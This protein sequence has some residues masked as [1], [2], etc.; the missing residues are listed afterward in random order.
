VSEH[1]T[2]TIVADFE[3]EIEDG[4]LP[5]P[6]CMVA[7]VL[8][9]HLRHVRTIRLWRE[10]LL[11]SKHPP[12][13]IGPD[14]LFVAY[15]AWADMTCFKVLGWQFPVH[16][17]DPHTAYLAASNVLLPYDPDEVRK[18][19]RK[20]LPDACR[21]YSIEGWGRIDKEQ[22]SED[23]GTGSWRK[24]GKEAVL[25]YCEEDVKKSAELLRAQLRGL[26]GLPP[27]DVPRTLFWSNYSASDGVGE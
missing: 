15:S 7:Y 8:D 17:F 13:D 25:N 12:F 18:K 22:I 20:R 27:A 4:G 5:N 1:F 23:I 24:Y 11:A 19:P 9:E 3:Y 10:E 16:I 26:L 6:L 2:Q 14:T 21:A